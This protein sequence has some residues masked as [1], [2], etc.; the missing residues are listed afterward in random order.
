MSKYTT[1]LRTIVDYLS[2]YDDTLT[3]QQKIEKARPLLFNFSYPFYNEEKRKEFETKII[4]YFYMR[5]IGFETVGLFKLYLETD[6]NIIM[7]VYNKYYQTIEQD[8]NYLVD[9]YITETN[10]SNSNG[11]SS[12][13]DNTTLTVSNNDT[14]LN[15]DFPQSSLN[16]GNYGSGSTISENT[17][18]NISDGDS[19]SKNN[20]FASSVRNLE[21]NNRPKAEL[22]SIYRDSLINVDSLVFG[23]LNKLFLNLY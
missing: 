5:E 6:L 9:T 15:S 17:S 12:S 1:E 20:N 2:G 18:T 10:S 4:R 22:I 11:T 23:E 21:G 19:S 13:E 7:P 8:Y 16:G 14:T 3:L